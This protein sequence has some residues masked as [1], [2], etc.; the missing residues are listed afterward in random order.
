[1]ANQEDYIGINMLNILTTKFK[2]D[3][4]TLTLYD[5]LKVIIDKHHNILIKKFNS[6]IDIDDI[7]YENI[8]C[9]NN[10]GLYEYYRR[11]SLVIDKVNKNK[12]KVKNAFSIA[13]DK[14]LYDIPKTTP[15]IDLEIND[16]VCI[17]G[18]PINDLKSSKIYH[19]TPFTQKKE[20]EYAPYN[21][22]GNWFSE[23]LDE[24]A[25]YLSSETDSGKIYE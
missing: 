24:S 14:L 13:E 8:I 5:L 18:L 16:K 21:M 2:L 10:K 11:T 6:S 20:A 19:G 7:K 12:I 25:A 17:I 1:M 23:R 22:Y 4:N 9:F 15:E 3:K